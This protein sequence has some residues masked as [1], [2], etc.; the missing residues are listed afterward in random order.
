MSIGNDM[1]PADIRACTE[2]NSGYG[3]GMGWGGDWSAWIIIFLIFGFFG[4]GGNGWGGGFGGGNGGVMD[5]YILTS[6]FAN[7][8]RKIDAVNNGICDGF[9]AMNTGMLNGFAGVNQNLNS[10]FQ[11]AELA[12][13]NQQAAL[14]L[15]FTL[16]D[17]Y[18]T[19]L[20]R[21]SRSMVT[22]H[23]VEA[24]PPELVYLKTYFGKY[25]VEK[26]TGSRPR[27]FSRLC[28]ANFLISNGT[29]VEILDII[30]S[31]SK[32]NEDLPSSTAA[33]LFRISSNLDK[34]SSV[35]DT[36]KYLQMYLN[37]SLRALSHTVLEQL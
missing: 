26:S 30:C 15:N 27:F 9:Y 14:L 2:G 28:L 4:W 1:S 36:P 6:D 22:L 11:A 16:S 10:G 33:K 3:G 34:F 19:N 35:A 18:V 8:E 5:G 29:S 17:K 21:F 24:L 25:T 23:C 31:R 20:F 7:I 32:V 37:G 12:R 13:C